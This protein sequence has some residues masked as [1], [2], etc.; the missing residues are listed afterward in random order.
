MAF[1]DRFKKDKEGQKPPVKRQAVNAVKQAAPRKVKAK[2]EPVAATGKVEK[3]ELSG[4]WRSLRHPMVT[5][6]SADLS[7]RLN[8]YIFKVNSDTNKIEIKK[9]IQDLYGVKVEGVNIVNTHSKRRR[10]GKS[11]G[12]RPGYKKA[13]IT[14]KQGDKI[15]SGV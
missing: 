12:T 8:Q 3:R 10:I 14:L 7:A 1:L 9:A 15:D 4:A 13:I 6:K 5:E 11:I 2:E